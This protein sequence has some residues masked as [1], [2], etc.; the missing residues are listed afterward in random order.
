[1]TLMF[2]DVEVGRTRVEIHEVFR[3]D[4][5]VEKAADAVGLASRRVQTELENFKRMIEGED[6]F[7]AE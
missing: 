2:T 7:P 3:P 5:I 4:G 6:P 1:V